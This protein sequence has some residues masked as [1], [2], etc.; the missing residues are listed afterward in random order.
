MLILVFKGK[1]VKVFE[2]W[3]RYFKSW[4]DRPVNVSALRGG[5]VNGR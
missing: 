3:D 4:C 5:E 1:A 2:E